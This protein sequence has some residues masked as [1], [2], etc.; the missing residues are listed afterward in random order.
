MNETVAGVEESIKIAL[1][2]A[3]AANDVTA[4]YVRVK[5]EHKQIEARASKLYRTG[6]I[7]IV[8]ATV[9]ALAAFAFAAL[10]YFVSVGEMRTMTKTNLESLVV[11]A[12]NVDRLTEALGSVQ[13]A[14]DK[15]ENVSA[16]A[17]T[18]SERVAALETSVR[19]TRTGLSDRMMA[20][21]DEMSKMNG[22]FAMSIFTK[23]DD[24]F[25]E[26]SKALS[27]VTK[28]VQ[29]L[30]NSVIEMARSGGDTA[31]MIALIDQQKRL[32]DQI[33]TM[34]AAQRTAAAPAKAAP[35]PVAKT[36]KPASSGND[37]I[38]FP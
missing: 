34:A 24:K 36:S 14:F 18:L 33:A 37:V 32:S 38:K 3:D 5:A 6:M 10:I 16:T 35:K 26:Q 31:S 13:Q 27:D 28:D 17:A 9:G 12:E 4:E 29:T 7:G 15:L 8:S 21:V 11:F 25:A 30:N 23:M 2:A 1:D 20:T 22:Q 19:E